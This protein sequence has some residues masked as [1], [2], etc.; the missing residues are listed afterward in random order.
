[1]IGRKGQGPGE[2]IRPQHIQVLPG[3]TIVVWDYMLHPAPTTSTPAGNFHP[4]APDLD[5]ATVLA[6]DTVGHR[7]LAGVDNGSP[8]WTAPSLCSGDCGTIPRPSPARFGG[9]P[10]STS[11]SILPTLFIHSGGGGG[12]ERLGMTTHHAFSY[13]WPPFARHI[14][15]SRPEGI[16]SVGVRHG[17]SSGS[18]FTSSRRNGGLRRIMQAGRRPGT[19]HERG[20][21]G[22]E[23][24]SRGKEP[25]RRRL[26]GLGAVARRRT[27]S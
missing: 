5:V 18:R 26:G 7:I 8:C 27:P 21:R 11:G 6:Q 13:P 22:V 23:G 25:P 12:R 16:P 3:D 2:F 15:A 9:D 4:Q 1:M 20:A 10:W 14:P 24:E 17:R 19:H